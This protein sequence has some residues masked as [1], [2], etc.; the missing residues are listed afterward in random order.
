MPDSHNMPDSLKSAYWMV[1][2]LASLLMG[3]F[4]FAIHG[5]GS[6]PKLWSQ[7]IQ[8]IWF[9][10][11]GSIAGWAALWFILGQTLNG[12]PEHA[13]E[14]SSFWGLVAVMLVG[15]TGYLPKLIH[16]LALLPEKW[17]EKLVGKS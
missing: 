2:V 11:V 13:P 6:W 17:I 16:G 10:F 14:G 5:D 12:L 8:Q 4:A 15:I 9:N 3:F 1:A 7:R